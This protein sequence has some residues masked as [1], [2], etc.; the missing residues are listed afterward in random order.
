LSQRWSHSYEMIAR[1]QG[2]ASEAQAKAAVE[3]LGRQVDEA[4]PDQVF[5]GWGAKAR[6]LAEARID[7]PTRTAVL[8]LFGAVGFVLLIACVN[9]ANLLL[10][11]AG[12]RR[13][14]IAIRLAIG[15]G[16]RRIVRQLLTESI[17]LALLGAVA[18]LTFAWWG[19]SALNA[20]N[21]ISSG[22]FGRSVSGLTRIGLSS[23][24]I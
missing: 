15:A 19:V 17:L 12:A 21:P 7:Q 6:T 10:A 5:R 8:V 24:R 22:A 20:I 16:R 2:G 1:R 13:R 4:H 3:L 14:E 23:I 18:G 9:I 11:R